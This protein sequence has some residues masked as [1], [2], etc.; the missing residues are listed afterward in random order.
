MEQW[1]ESYL[2]L[3]NK[4][5]SDASRTSSAWLAVGK[6]VEAMQQLPPKP[7][8]AGLR[9]LRK[10]LRRRGRLDKFEAG[11]RMAGAVLGRVHTRDECVR[12]GH[13]GGDGSRQLRGNADAVDRRERER[14]GSSGDPQ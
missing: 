2:L 4:K 11:T 13:L 10:E 1:V 14:Q 5:E 7:V 9:T 6:E 12:R 3:T 8:S